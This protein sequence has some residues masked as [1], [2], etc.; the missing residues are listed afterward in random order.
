MGNIVDEFNIYFNIT[1]TNTVYVKDCDAASLAHLSG[2]LIL[3]DRVDE[4]AN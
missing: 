1:L 3:K 2:T 4:S